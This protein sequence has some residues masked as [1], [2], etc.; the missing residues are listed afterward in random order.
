MKKMKLT[1]LLCMLALGVQAQPNYSADR[2]QEKLDRGLNA[3]GANNTTVV[4]WRYFSSEKDC[5]YQLYRNGRLMVETK[6]TSHTIPVKANA[7]D[8]YQL[9]VIDAAGNIIETSAEV[10]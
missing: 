8:T 7:S 3:F 5:K 1:A 2:Q 10:N 6:K 9:K 4:N